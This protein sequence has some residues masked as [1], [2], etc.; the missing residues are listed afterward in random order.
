VAR[1]I[2]VV[3]V[4]LLLLGCHDESCRSVAALDFEPPPVTAY[5]TALPEAEG[6]FVVFGDTQR[7]SWQE[8]VIGHEVNDAATATLIASVTDAD[9]AFVVVVGDFVFHG[10][11]EEHWQLFD[12][13]AA[14]LR[15]A[16]TPWLP[17]VGNHE[18]WGRNKSALAH[19]RDRFS[20]LATDTWY[21]DRYGSLG[22]VVVDS[23][24]AELDDSAWQRQAEWYSA[25]MAAFN[26]D[27]DIQGILVFAHHPPF[28]NS[29]I[30]SGDED[31]QATFVPAFCESAK[32]LA[33]IAGH[34][35]GYE[36]FVR[37]PDEACGSREHHF[38]VT[39]GGGGPRPDSLR[40][41]EDTGHKD[42]Y[43]GPAPRPFH[44]LWMMPTAEGVSVEVRGFQR[45]D[46]EAQPRETFLLAY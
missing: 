10:A 28:T 20:R 36:R 35:H 22:L 11:D 13:T 1:R 24:V 2:G 7:T 3:F 33:F 5:V 45:E 31:V 14:P 6:G 39:A 42:L 37:G 21:S 30:V 44:Y 38:I 29:T 18:Y 43:D 19:L 27:P 17:V 41:V 16:G 40:S 15:D 34:A 46:T 23:N 8:C 26:D 12:V 25:E 9:P 32:G 4:S